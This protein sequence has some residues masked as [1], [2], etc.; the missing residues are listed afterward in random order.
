[1][2]CGLSVCA[3]APGWALHR[4]RLCWNRMRK[5]ELRLL[6]TTGHAHQP[7][8]NN[9][10]RFLKLDINIMFPSKVFMSP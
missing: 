2:R 10:M 4:M 5:L 7:G 6:G 8:L 1:M 9:V 3:P